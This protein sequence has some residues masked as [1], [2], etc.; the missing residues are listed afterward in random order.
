MFL[1][2]KKVNS[3][4]FPSVSVDIDL[5]CLISFFYDRQFH[6]PLLHKVSFRLF[7]QFEHLLGFFSQ[8]HPSPTN[9]F[10]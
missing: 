4:F 5:Y 2:R 6:N 10:Y 1:D 7:Y 3:C 9:W 8:A